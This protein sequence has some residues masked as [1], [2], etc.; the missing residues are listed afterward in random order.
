VLRSDRLWAG[1]SADLVIEVLMRNMKTS[2]GLT[3]GRGM[4]E[5]QRI[6]MVMSHYLCSEI[7]NAMQP[8]TGL[9]YNTSDQHKDLTKARQERDVT[10]SCELL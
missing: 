6:L 4:T 3:R 8:F 1:L 10:D 2:G 5:I 9:N 7:N